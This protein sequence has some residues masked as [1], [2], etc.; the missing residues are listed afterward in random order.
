LRIATRAELIDQI[1]PATAASV[2][3]IVVVT[4]LHPPV[5]DPGH[6]GAWCACQ[7]HGT[8][9]PKRVVYPLNEFVAGHGRIIS[10]LH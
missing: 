10:P 2:D 5:G 4:P 6:A 1:C 8:P 3:S 9:A 7:D